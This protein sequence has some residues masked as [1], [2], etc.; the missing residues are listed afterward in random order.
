[1]TYSLGSAQNRQEASFND[2]LRPI[3]NAM[4]GMPPLLAR[5]NRPLQMTFEDQINPITQ[6]VLGFSFYA[7][8]VIGKRGNSE[9]GSI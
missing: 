7:S 2:L 5:G 6:L 8:C 1:M 9:A 3:Q 4:N